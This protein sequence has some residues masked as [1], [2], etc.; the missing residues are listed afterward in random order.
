MVLLIGIHHLADYLKAHEKA[1][2]LSDGEVENLKNNY[3]WYALLLVLSAFLEVWRFRTLPKIRSGLLRYDDARQ[4]QI[5]LDENRRTAEAT[6]VW[7]GTPGKEDT[8]KTPL[9]SDA[10]RQENVLDRPDEDKSND[11][12]TAAQS[13]AWWEDPLESNADRH[14]NV[15]NKPDENESNDE[16]TATESGAWWEDP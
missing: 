1:L 11:E 7:E 6:R 4:F 3:L 2:Y 8:M 5:E 9:L 14:E 15:W 16:V 13:G 10:D 12:F